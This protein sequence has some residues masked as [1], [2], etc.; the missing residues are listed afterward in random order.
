MIIFYIIEV[1]RFFALIISQKSGIILLETKAHHDT[2]TTTD[3][4]ILVNGKLP[5]KDFVAQALKNS[6]WLR[7]EI[8]R[9]LQVKPWVTP[10]VVFTNAFVKFGRRSKGYV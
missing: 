10:L 5:E 9:L 3:S 6:Y 7:E 8:E 4:E 2:V 1:N